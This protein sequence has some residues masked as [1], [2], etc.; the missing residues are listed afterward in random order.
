M[1]YSNNPLLAKARKWSVELVIKE[2]LPIS[3][4]ARRAGVHR[5]TLWHWLKRW[6]EIN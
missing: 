5:V 1:S 4:A 2:G 6:Q 3:V